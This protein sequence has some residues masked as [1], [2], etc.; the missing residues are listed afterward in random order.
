[1]RGTRRVGATLLEVL[2]ALVLL[3]SVGL[4][5]IELSRFAFETV[6]IAEAGGDETAAASNFMNAV[7]L[8]STSELNQ[9]LG[10]REQGRWRLEIQRVDAELYLVTLRDSTSQ[11]TVLQTGLFR[12]GRS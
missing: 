9:R 5:G 3:A 4:T 6:R 11:R 10:E 1:M 2:V 7:A 8:W 12:P